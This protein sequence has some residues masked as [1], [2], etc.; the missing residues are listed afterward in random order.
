MQNPYSLLYHVTRGLLILATS[1]LDV[2]SR[3]C[4]RTFTYSVAA[5]YTTD[6]ENVLFYD[7]MRFIEVQKQAIYVLYYK[8]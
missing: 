6:V 5:G 4:F 3:K 2:T 8:R 1:C 7:F